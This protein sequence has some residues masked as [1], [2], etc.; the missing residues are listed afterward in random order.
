MKAKPMWILIADGA[1]ARVLETTGGASGLSEVPGLDLRADHR[2]SH[3][4]RSDEPSRSYESVGAARHAVEPRTDPHR[5]LKRTFAHQLAA[6]LDERFA[7]HEFDRL[8]L[9][10]PPQMLGD[11]RNAI[12]HSVRVKIAAE[13]AMDLFKVPDSELG[14]HLKGLVRL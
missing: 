8:V 2:S 4:I 7:R 6:M 9:V 10:A 11:L 14:A 1:R 13:L 3:E 5:E 12:S